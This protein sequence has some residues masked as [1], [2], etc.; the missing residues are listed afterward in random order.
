MAITNPFEVE[1][2]SAMPEP[3]H[4]GHILEQRVAA[5]PHEREDTQRDQRY[6]HNDDLSGEIHRQPLDFRVA[7]QYQQDPG[8]YRVTG[9]QHAA[10]QFAGVGVVGRDGVD[11]TE[12]PV[13]GHIR[14]L[15]PV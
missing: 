14:C 2:S 13:I 8:L 12:L 15:L 6:G 9:F 7:D 4:M 11:I 1:F 3:D 5:D 10:H